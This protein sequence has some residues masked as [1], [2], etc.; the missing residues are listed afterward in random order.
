MTLSGDGRAGSGPGDSRRWGIAVVKVALGIALTW[1][2]LRAAGFRLAEAGSSVDWTLLRP[3]IPVLL[4]S[5]GALFAAF[6]LQARLWAWLLTHFGGP[7]L[8]LAVATA[9]ILV[10]NMGRYIPGKV[11]QLAAWPCLR[12][13]KAYPGC[14]PAWP[15]SPGRS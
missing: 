13:V 12:S 2:I 9:M 5:M 11:F 6:A 14:R 8:R 3:N 1:L 10:A 15:R 7:P 4:L